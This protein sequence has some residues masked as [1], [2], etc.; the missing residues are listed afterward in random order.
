MKKYRYLFAA[1]ALILA[2]CASKDEPIEPGTVVDGIVLKADL[3]DRQEPD[4]KTSLSQDGSVYTVLWKTGDKI[5]INGTES[6]AV[7]SGDNGKRSVDFTVS[8]PLSAPFKVLYPGT[9]SANQISLPDT[10]YYVADVLTELLL[11]P[12]VMQ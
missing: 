7:E 4:T 8:G 2:S 5:S 6:A 12:M 1:A 11:L 3:P 9:T 10:Q